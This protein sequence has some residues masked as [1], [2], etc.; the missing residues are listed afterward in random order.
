MVQAAP[1]ALS[2][3]P[4]LYH[5]SESI[6]PPTTMIESLRPGKTPTAVPL[7]VLTPLREWLN[8]ST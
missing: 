3:A 7:R 8:Q 2:L 6:C 5:L 1:E 4:G